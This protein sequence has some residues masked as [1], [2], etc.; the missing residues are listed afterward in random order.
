MKQ[1][2]KKLEKGITLIALVITI[3]VLLI[4]AGISVAMLTGDNGILNKSK[5]A[6][7]Q[8]EI[9]ADI[10]TLKLE[11][12]EYSTDKSVTNQNKTYLEHLEEK[13]YIVDYI[14]DDKKVGT[15]TLNGRVYDVKDKEK[16]E[17]TYKGEASG[18]VLLLPRIT[19]LDMLVKNNEVQINVQLKDKNG[20]TIKYSIQKDGE[21]KN[22][23][24][25][26]YIENYEYTFDNLES[27]TTYIV[28]VEVKNK[29]GT[30]IRKTSIKTI[31][32]SDLTLGKASFEIM[33]NAKWQTEINAKIISSYSESNTSLQYKINDGEW[34]EYNDE[35]KVYSNGTLYGRYYNKTTGEI[36][37]AFTLKVDVIDDIKP[38]I[39]I[40]EQ[41]VTAKTIKITVNVKDNELGMP[42]TI[43]Y[44]YY[45]G[46]N[47][48][49]YVLKDT[50]ENN[51]NYTYKDLNANNTYYIKIT[52]EDKAG[53]EGETIKIINT[54][55]PILVSNIKLNKTSITIGTTD[56]VQLNASVSP[57][58]A[59]DKTVKWSTSDS[60]IA[61]VSNTGVVKPLKSGNVTIT[62][63]S[64]DGGATADCKVNVVNGSTI[65]T[66]EDLEAIE[67]TGKYTLMNDIDLSGKD[68]TPISK[69]NGI[70]DG[71]G[72]SIKNLTIK[73]TGT[74]MYIGFFKK[75]ADPAEIKN[76]KFENVSVSSPNAYVGGI[77]GGASSASGSSGQFKNSSANKSI[78][79]KN[80]GITNGKIKGKGYVSSFGYSSGSKEFAVNITD[81]YSHADITSTSGYDASGLLSGRRRKTG[82]FY[83]YKKLLGR[84]NECKE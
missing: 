56:T 39:E 41:E 7:E 13:G 12:S 30:T 35:F 67:T 21:E 27:S 40:T 16:L 80:V 46:T 32:L 66:R 81:C 11:Y 63:S 58:N 47:E 83:I 68:W 73:D 44:N 18:D 20:V 5:N 79:I 33:P 65:Y 76:I 42:S 74:D 50:L 78:T 6:K 15:V 14:N 2:T 84:N 8:S 57:D 75:I 52:T 23:K 28:T 3:I 82:N 54:S 53:N 26:T 71:N 45:I 43:K 62:C 22:L 61:T 10:E 55:N 48:N 38:V 49:D 1:K 34:G 29:Y 4:L 51:N 69:F 24:E 37:Y 77:F 19:K 70:L 64:L 60:S 9:S 31:S 59:E 72:Y 17:I 25:S 36:G